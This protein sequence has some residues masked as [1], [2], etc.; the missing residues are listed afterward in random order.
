[1]ADVLRLRTTY[2]LQEVGI[3]DGNGRLTELAVDN[4]ELAQKIGS[5]INNPSVIKAL[6]NDGS[7]LADWVKMTTQSV[8]LSNGQRSK[9][10]IIKT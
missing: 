3:I 10:A 7:N 5:S 9:F 4:S 2:A 8:Q 1:M 6:T